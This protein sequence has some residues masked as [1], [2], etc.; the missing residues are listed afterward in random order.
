[1]MVG[2]TL[3][4][5]AL[6]YG[7]YVYATF[8]GITAA[9]YGLVC[10]GRRRPLLLRSWMGIL[11]G[12]AAAAAVLLAQLVAYMGWRNVKLD[13]AYTLAARNMASDKA[14][15]ELVDRFYREHHI[16]FWNNYFDISNSRTLKAFVGSFLQKHLQYYSPWICLAAAVILAGT[17]LGLMRRTGARGPHAESSPHG[18]ATW[19]RFFASRVLPGIVVAAIAVATL[20][21]ARPVFDDSSAT[22][23]SAALGLAPP[24]WMGWLGY[25]IASAI[26]LA[27]AVAGTG[28]L[29][30]RANRLVGL[31][32][33]SLCVVVAYA[34]VYRIFTGYIFSGY[35]N[36]Q[37]PFLVF[38]T[39][40]LLAGAVYIVVET[41]RRAFAQSQSNQAP[42]LLPISGALLLLFF[43]AAWSTLQLSY[44]IVVPPDSQQFLRLLAKAPFRGSS[45]VVNSYAA[46]ESEETRAWAY[47]ETSLFSGRVRLAPNGFQVEHDRQYL[48]FADADTNP[49]YLKPDY[50]LMI[51][52]PASIG[53]ALDAYA[54]RSPWDRHPI[55]FESTGLIR[56][57]QEPLQPFLRHSL[58]RTDGTAFSIVKFDWDFPPF[59]KPVDAA[60]RAAAERM[61]FRQKLSF[62]ESSQEQ[63]RRWRVEVGP[64]ESGAARGHATVVLDEASIDGRPIFSNAALLEAGWMPGA[65]GQTWT[66][67]PG[68]SGTVAAVGVGDA[69]TLRLAEGPGSGAARVAINDMVQTVDL[70]KARTSEHVIALSTAEA[71]DKFTA[72]P[73][74]TPGMYVNAWLTAG[75]SGPAAVL[76]Y[77]YAHQE[78]NPED[79]TTVR[80]YNEPSP[81][82]WQ[83]ADSITFLGPDAIPVRLDEFRSKNPDT[84]RE[85]ARM[86]ASGD[87]RTYQQWLTDHL[88]TYPNDRHREGIVA[89]DAPPQ[90]PMPGP[91]GS[92][93]RYRAIPL[94]VGLKGRL[95]LSI[96]PCTRTKAGPEYFGLPFDAGSAESRLQGRLD[97]I[98]IETPADFARKDFPYGYVRLRL[99]FP[100]HREPQAEPI[101]TAGVEEAGDFVYVVYADAT[102]VRIGFDHWFKGG[103]L[104]PPIP[105]DLSKEHDL[106][107]SMGSLF[108]PSDD[109]VF[110]GMDSALVDELKENVRVTLDGKTV[111][112]APSEF[113]DSPP[114]Q[115]AI[116]RNDIKGTTSNTRFSGEIISW[117]RV[118][119]GPQ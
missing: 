1:M 45:F 109:I 16:I 23:W 57:T 59:L 2:G 90:P 58:V 19:A 77:R 5:A 12:G 10:Y 117:K 26:A 112:Q 7:E 118:W 64:V 105:I 79:G 14:F 107:V 108:P 74:L 40:T 84:L 49:S 102:H 46:P 94:P 62:S 106:E 93:I 21:F 91:T 73:H 30:G 65:G 75:A 110:V 68:I 31:F 15:T 43:I 95:Q 20:R 81:G 44:L 36:R 6:F 29:V 42:A 38:W 111:I 51:D 33:L 76:G 28:G 52:Q 61:T 101:V 25:V 41:T 67:I 71:H 116:G 87:T 47:A 53:Q 34:V 104:S 63:L 18:V 85:F 96:T 48:W 70:R 55:A 83:L 60:L 82:S 56:R 98:D 99:R 86:Q 50:G 78:G 80:V 72:I 97:P 100:A 9:C 22:L 35:L 66:G 114:T 37:A 32:S 24:S 4:F 92:P 8:V 39:D 3:A 119:P 54:G 88:T 69:V 113:W 103:P 89:M 115:V 11:A 17:L 27:L 13:I